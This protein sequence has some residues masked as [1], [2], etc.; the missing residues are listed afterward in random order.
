MNRISSALVAALLLA[1][2]A[3]AQSRYSPKERA[4]NRQ[5]QRADRQEQRDDKR[6]LAALKAVLADFDRARAHKSDREMAAVEMRLKRLLSA[7]LSE[8]RVEL[9]S[10]KAEARRSA[11]EVRHADGRWESVDDRHD[12]RDDRRDVQ[13]EAAS[14]RARLR[15]ARELDSLVGSRRAS[16]LKR[17]RT[18]LVELIN[19]GEQEL[20]QNGQERREDRRERR[21]DRR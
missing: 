11:K 5:E 19:L 13:A 16:D 14:Q 6:D 4:Q 21:E 10:D 8:G 9:A 15:V 3:Q 17:Q 1:G 2:S 18:L 7:E 20:R 12:R